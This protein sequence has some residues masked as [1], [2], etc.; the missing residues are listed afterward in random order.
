MNLAERLKP[1]ER[2]AVGELGFWL[3]CQRAMTDR[4]REHVAGLE[5]LGSIRAYLV[6]RQAAGEQR[7]AQTLARR[8]V[9]FVFF[10]HVP[11]TGGSSFRNHIRTQ[12]RDRSFTYE[13]NPDLQTR[14]NTGDFSA[15]FAPT[16]ASFFDAFDVAIGHYQFSEIP[17]V[18]LDHGAVVTACLRDP[19]AR[20][21]SLYNFIRRE[22]GNHP[23]K[24]ELSDRTI[25]EAFEHVRP[26]RTMAT[27]GQ[28]RFVTGTDTAQAAMQV[29]ERHR[30]LIGRVEEMDRFSDRLAALLGLEKPRIERQVNVGAAGYKDK[31]AAQPD[32]DRFEE[33]ATTANAEE[34]AFYDRLGALY[35][36]V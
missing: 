14:R 35:D 31:V 32:F 29:V 26:F 11:K 10:V 18:A 34:Q 36:G 28:L 33:M 21:V 22:E 25:A 17:T 6:R 23:L 1:E 5:T 15:L 9:P 13:R 20:V 16:K 24:E 7:M 8:K 30:F 4:E 19:L 12:K 27:N 2:T 3:T